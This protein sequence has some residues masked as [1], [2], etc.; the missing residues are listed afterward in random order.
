MTTWSDSTVTKLKQFIQNPLIDNKY[1]GST[2][3]DYLNPVLIISA[4]E[5]AILENGLEVALPAFNCID[6]R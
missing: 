5:N 4:L 2:E 3:A 1:P 6:I